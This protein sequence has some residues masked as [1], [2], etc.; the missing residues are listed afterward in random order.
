MK[1]HYKNIILTFG[2]TAA[3]AG[4]G[5]TKSMMPQSVK[6]DGLFGNYAA[7]DSTSLA[8]MHWNEL[9]TDPLLQ[10]LISEGLKNNFDLQIA[11]QKVHE[12]EAYLQQSTAALL[13][14][15]SLSG[16][17]I[18]MRNS[19]STYPNAP[20]NMDTEQLE[21]GASWELD[22]WGKLK[23]AKRAYYANLLYS[24]A[25]RKAV[26]T[27]LIADIANTYYQLLALDAQLSITEETV[28]KDIDLV[29][30]MKVMKDSGKVTGAAVM[31]SEA[32]RYSAEV[33]IP[34]IKQQIRE[35]ENSL[36]LLLGR[37]G[38]TTIDRGK[39]EQQPPVPVMR[40]GVPAR[41]LEN[42]PDVMEAGYLVVKAYETIKGAKANFYPSLTI[43][44][45][46][47]FEALKMNELFDPGS[48][49]ANV[50]GG[51]TQPVLDKKINI[52]KL[53]VAK[54]QQEEAL[55]NFKSSLLNA[56]N[57]V[58]NAMGVYQSS[59][60]KTKL[61][62]SQLDAL[63]KSVDYTQELLTYGSANYTELLIAQQSLLVAQL[64]NVNDR[65]QQLKS[66]VSLY[67]ALGGGWKK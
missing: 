31:Q 11:V 32:S 55:L 59:V 46:S 66:V 47:G 58:Q 13:P 49:A 29:E 37:A 5:S 38:G 65:L 36:C 44:A 63:I 17:R 43:T 21:F 4:C 33:T 16:N 52:T 10:Q 15:V 34:D 25:G 60:T 54:A 64:N 7:T 28:Q 3:L 53:K 2:L 56:G 1:I 30:T 35:T 23:S 48:F 41:L 67:R 12:A 50:I 40:T 18:Y 45:S 39:I 61:R 51:L 62:E 20:L 57:E 26:Q 9:F 22:I 6:T 14:D 42:R 19:K 24:D 27:R 8:D